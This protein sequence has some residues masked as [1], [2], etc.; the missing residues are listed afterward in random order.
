MST[1]IDA[2][3]LLYASDESSRQTSAQMLCFL[4]EQVGP[5]GVVRHNSQVFPQTPLHSLFKCVY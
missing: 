2:N 4:P 5:G 3:V 1:T